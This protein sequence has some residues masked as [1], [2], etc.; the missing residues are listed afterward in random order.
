MPAGSV[1]AGIKDHGAAQAAVDVYLEA[2]ARQARY[3]PGVSV[4]DVGGLRR[5]R[6]DLGGVWAHALFTCG[7]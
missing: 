4:F 2:A 6:S 5:T 1:R 3:A 7:A